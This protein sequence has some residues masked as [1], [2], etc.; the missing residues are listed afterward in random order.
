MGVGGAAA[1]ITVVIDSNNSNNS[2]N[3]SG[4]VFVALNVGAVVFTVVTASID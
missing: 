2:G 4:C 1:D 3:N